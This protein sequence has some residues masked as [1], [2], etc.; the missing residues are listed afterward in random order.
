MPGVT[1]I[2]TNPQEKKTMKT[3]IIV[4][5]DRSGSMESKRADVIGGYN[6]FLKEQKALTV[7]A[8]RLFG[9]QFNTEF[10][11]MQPIAPI[12]V[13]GEL[14]EQNY[15]PGGSTALLDAF[16]H[17]M[18]QAEKEK[19]ADERA[20]MLIITDGE[21]NSSR[22]TSYEKVA[23][24]VKAKEALGDW[25]FTYLGVSLD[26]WHHRTGFALNNIAPYDVSDPNKSF[27]RASQ[28]TSDLRGSPISSTRNFYEVNPGDKEPDKK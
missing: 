7:D 5:L 15:I 6:R 26:K 12:Q 28:S 14:S 20:L 23:E 9:T 24:M 3:L 17:T 27:A 4:L 2:F 13:A 16:M 25:T 8:C 1:D 21:E 18:V 22:E 11:I 19:Q 10:T